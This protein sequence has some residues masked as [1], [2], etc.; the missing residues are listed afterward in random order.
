M[1]LIKFTLET[2]SEIILSHLYV[3][4]NYHSNLTTRGTEIVSTDLCSRCF[5]LFCRLTRNTC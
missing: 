3:K 4:Q 5:R 2:I 1:R